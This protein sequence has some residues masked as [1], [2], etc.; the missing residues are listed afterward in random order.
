M[1]VFLTL[2]KT[3][4]FHHGSVMISGWGDKTV[5]QGES[6]EWKCFQHHWE[7][8]IFHML[9]SHPPS[10]FP[11]KARILQPYCTCSRSW[12][13]T[14]GSFISAAELIFTLSLVWCWGMTFSW[15]T[16]DNLILHRSLNHL[17]D[18]VLILTQLFSAGPFRGGWLLF[19]C[20]KLTLCWSDQ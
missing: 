7:H 4:A 11:L 10:K 14:S 3:L 1:H 8:I 2:E 6:I 15:Q 19:Q 17:P 20:V 12:R 16:K 18:V 5:L 13:W 9:D